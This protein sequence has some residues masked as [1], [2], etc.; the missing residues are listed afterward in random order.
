MNACEALGAPKS[1]LGSTPVMVHA[2]SMRSGSSGAG[3]VSGGS[4]AG[5]TAGGLIAAA[6]RVP[7]G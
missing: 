6:V 4:A 7:T 3:G 1:V 5:S 2:C